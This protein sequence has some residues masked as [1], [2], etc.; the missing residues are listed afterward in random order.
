MDTTSQPTHATLVQ[1]WV[2][3]P[4][5]VLRAWQTDDLDAF[6]RLTADPQVVRYVGDG[7]VLSREQT[8]EWIVIAN[9]NIGKWGFGTHA[10][11]ERESGSVIGWAG[12][13]H[14]DQAQETAAEII[15]AL[16]PAAWGRGYATELARGIL[17]WAWRH[18]KLE[19]VIATIAPDNA[20][21][22]AMM[23]KL[24]FVSEGIVMH[25]GEVPVAHFCYPRPD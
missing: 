2:E 1:P 12:L 5:I 8:A 3:T 16:S 17:D 23:G 25:D 10:V 21:S 24:G 19:R 13:I 18:S 11:V 20:A 14:S 22:I 7:T 15:Y 9:R 6:A 4:R